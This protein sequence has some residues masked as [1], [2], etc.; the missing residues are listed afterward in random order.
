[1]ELWDE[2]RGTVNV[3]ANATYWLHGCYLVWSETVHG[4]HQWWRHSIFSGRDPVQQPGEVLF[5][6]SGRKPHE[7]ST[8]HDYVYGGEWN[9]PVCGFPELLHRPESRFQEYCGCYAGWLLCLCGW[10]ESGWWCGNRNHQDRLPQRNHRFWG[11]T[12]KG[13]Q[14]LVWTD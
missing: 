6:C 1:M 14:H 10:A 9:E 13:V 8:E 5:R 2:R 3:L 11:H 4:N 7:W 12:G